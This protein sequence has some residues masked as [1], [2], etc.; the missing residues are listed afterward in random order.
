MDQ[1][2]DII[3]QNIS[4][5][6]VGKER[7]VDLLLCAL[8]CRG[9][10]LIEDVPGTGKTT[11]A[12]ALAHSL[13]CSFQ[14]I[15]F[16]PDIM[17]SDI[18][19]F[20]IPDP[21]TKKFTYIPGALMHQIV[22]AD[23]INRTSPK[24]QSALLEAMQ[25]NQVTVDG[26]THPVPL[27]FMV[28]ATQNP[29]EHAGTFSLPEAQLD[30]F[31]M[32]L[33]LGYPTLEEEMHIL[34]MHDNGG[35]PADLSAVITADGVLRLQKAVDSVHASTALKEYIS[36]FVARTRK[37]P[38]I[39]LGVSTRGAIN[40][41]CAAKGY[42]FLRGRGYATA[43]DVQRLALPV[44]A[45]RIKLTSEARMKRHTPESIL[46]RILEDAMLPEA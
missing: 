34:N 20:S 7:V 14:R 8:I 19:G 32:H 27:P 40:L 37:H 12:S 43:E 1:T 46:R 6:L 10:V 18:T 44:L 31:F 13:G 15:Q 42:A 22:L 2:L 11:L 29:I 24:T 28:I 35:P 17:P 21:V 39:S 5:K 26:R 4:R 9:H 23:E 45:H 25:E 30:R 38:A 3:R 16:T 33:R 41:M 36:D